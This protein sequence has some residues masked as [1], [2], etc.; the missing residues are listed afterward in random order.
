MPTNHDFEISGL[1]SHRLNERAAVT[2]QGA[3]VTAPGVGAAHR[4]HA[5]LVGADVSAI[6]F[7]HVQ[8]VTHQ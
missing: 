4:K 5:D 2:A 8:K 6:P 3:E 7:F 1:P